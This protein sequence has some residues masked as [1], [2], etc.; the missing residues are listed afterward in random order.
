[1]QAITEER[2]NDQVNPITIDK[3]RDDLNLCFE[4]LNMKANE[5]NDSE[6]VV[7]LALSNG[8]FK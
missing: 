4:S 5:E 1:M 2:L 7:D 3:I 6:V 8:Q